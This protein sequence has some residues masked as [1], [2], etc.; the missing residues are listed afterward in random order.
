LEAYPDLEVIISDGYEVKFYKLD[1]AKFS[2]YNDQL[3]IGIGGCSF[4]E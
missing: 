4:E 2:I 1:D 3:D